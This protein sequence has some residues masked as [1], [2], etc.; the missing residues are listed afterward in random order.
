MKPTNCHTYLQVSP[1]SDVPCS[2]TLGAW[3]SDARAILNDD[4]VLE[5]G[6][7]KQNQ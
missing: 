1:I 3:T 6:P 2:L 5:I 7:G 4:E